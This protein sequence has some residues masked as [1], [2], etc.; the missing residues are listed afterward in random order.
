MAPRN[1]ARKAPSSQPLSKAL[2]DC[3]R[4][5]RPVFMCEFGRGRAAVEV[6]E[7][8]LGDIA[9]QTQLGTDVLTAIFVASPRT[10][11]RLHAPHCRRAYSATQLRK[12]RP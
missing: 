10:W 9:I 3:P 6:L 5:G 8:P 12:V 1:V 11:Y 7:R 2:E 4:C